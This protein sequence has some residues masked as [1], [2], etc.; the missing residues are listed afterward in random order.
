MLAAED[1]YID[2]ASKSI[3]QLST[4]EKISKRCFDRAIYYREKQFYEKTIAE[5]QAEI[6][7]KNAELADKEAL[8][9]KLLSE[10]E[11]LKAASAKNA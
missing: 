9:Q 7:D 1:Q 5:Q 2:E 10:N 6:A 3:F 11:N 4:E 8:I